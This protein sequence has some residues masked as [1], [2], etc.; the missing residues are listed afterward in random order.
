MDYLAAVKEFH[1]TYGNPIN[2]RP[3]IQDEQLNELR[4]DLLRE[5]L[6]EMA[7]GL[8]TNNPVEVLDA[9]CDQLYVL[10]GAVLAFGFKDVFNAAFAEVQRSNM[11]KLDEDGNP[12]YREDGKVLKGPNYSPPDIKR[13]LEDG[14]LL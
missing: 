14:G 9:L 10:M 13:I 11:S 1:E 2:D 7:V 8:E 12:I 4:V 5:E 6:G 3:Y